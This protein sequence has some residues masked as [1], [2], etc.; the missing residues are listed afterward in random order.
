MSQNAEDFVRKLIKV[1]RAYD[2]ETLADYLSENLAAIAADYRGAAHQ[3]AIVRADGD[4]LSASA[5]AALKF[6]A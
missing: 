2:E 5:Q 6:K 4:R 1:A 3:T